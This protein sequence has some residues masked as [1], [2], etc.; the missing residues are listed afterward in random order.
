MNW[1][2]CNDKNETLNDIFATNDTVGTLTATM[3][4]N[5]SKLKKE[6]FCLKNDIK[7]IQDEMVELRTNNREL[8]A[9]IIKFQEEAVVH[10]NSLLEKIFNWV[11]RSKKHS[12]INTSEVDLTKK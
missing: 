1:K 5:V 12:R 11:L 10:Q 9:Q 8:N 6:I 3:I 2:I 7:S 4:D